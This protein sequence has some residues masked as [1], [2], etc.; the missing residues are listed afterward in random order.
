[1]GLTQPDI[2]SSTWAPEWE[3]LRQANPGEAGRGPMTGS[4]TRQSRLGDSAENRLSPGMGFK[5]PRHYP[6]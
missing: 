4:R 5:T 3:W 2:V 1:M 6:E